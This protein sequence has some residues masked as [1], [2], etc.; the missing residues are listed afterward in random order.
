MDTTG[1]LSSE[2]IYRFLVATCVTDTK[3]KQSPSSCICR[4]HPTIGRRSVFS[5][6]N[7]AAKHLSRTFQVH[8][9][10]SSSSRTFS[11][12][13]SNSMP[14][15]IAQHGRRNSSSSSITST[16]TLCNSKAFSRCNRQ[17]FPAHSHTVSIF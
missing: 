15:A 6:L 17:Q 5:Q 4:D 3:R 2:Q 11:N 12:S 14:R 8:I 1:R 9:S 13:S 10:S 16:T 7:K